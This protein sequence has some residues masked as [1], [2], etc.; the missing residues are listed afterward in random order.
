MPRHVVSWQGTVDAPPLPT[1]LQWIDEARAELDAGRPAYAQA[2]GLYLH[3]A[4]ADDV[5]EAAGALLLDAYR[6]LG[7]SAFAGILE[8]HLRHRDLPSVAVF[9]NGDPTGS[10]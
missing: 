10:V 5:R 2:L 3:W 4:D 1:R 7:F 6:A 8:A 9:R